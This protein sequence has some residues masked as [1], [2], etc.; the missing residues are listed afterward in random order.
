MI[1]VKGK[2]EGIVGHWINVDE[3]FVS[4]LYGWGQL[5][6]VGRTAYVN[7]EYQLNGCKGYGSEWHHRFGRGGGKRDDRIF[8][9][10]GSRGMFWTCRNCHDKLRIERKPC[11]SGGELIAISLEL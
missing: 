3:R 11:V 8:L 4:T 6:E 5:K 7:C 10:D 1:R 2:W 9:P